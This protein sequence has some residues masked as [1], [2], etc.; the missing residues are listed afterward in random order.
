MGQVKKIIIV[1]QRKGIVPALDGGA[2]ET[3]LENIIN[4]NEKYHNLDIVLIEPYDERLETITNEYKYTKFV[5]IKEVFWKKIIPYIIYKLRRFINIQREMIHPYICEA[6]KEIN[7]HE[8]F[9]WLI[10]EEG[11]QVEG[12]IKLSKKYKGKVIYHS[13]LHEIPINGTEYDKVITV[14]DFCRREWYKCLSKE[15]T[16][17]VYNGVDQER[18]LKRITKLERESLRRKLNIESDCFLVLYCG[19]INADKGVREL[20]EAILKIDDRKVKLMIVGASCFSGSGQTKYTKQLE[21]LT[22]QQAD[23]FI[24]T[25]YVDNMELYKY[26]QL[27]D[28]QC[29]PSICEEAAG[30]VAIE[31]MLSYLPLIVTD[32]G[33]LREYARYARVVKRGTRIV[34]N[35]AKEIIWLKCNPEFSEAIAEKGFTFAK[36]FNVTNMYKSFVEKM[37]E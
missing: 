33:G 23:R 35:L 16:S 27:A 18:F 21:E 26:Y 29:I 36:K 5:F 3:L 14:S 30:L 20:A 2:V 37:Y 32:S 17:V 12:Y 11:E 28:I 7:N 1:A 24:F 6:Y 25:G 22:K 31:G 15:A 4:E 34:E 10:I 8:Y 9:D 19:R 13:H